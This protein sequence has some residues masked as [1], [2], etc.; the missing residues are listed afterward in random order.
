MKLPCM[1]VVKFFAMWT[2]KL[3]NAF[4][5]NSIN[6]RGVKTTELFN[7]ILIHKPPFTLLLYLDWNPD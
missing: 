1:E 7:S 6:F 5:Q 2:T 3:T 4:F